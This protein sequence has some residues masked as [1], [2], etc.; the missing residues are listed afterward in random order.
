MYARDYY[1]KNKARIAEHRKRYRAANKEKIRGSKRRDRG[2]PGALRPEP[3]YCELCGGADSRAL[4]LDH[5]HATGV[6]RGWI[7]NLCNMGLARFRDDPELMRRA[8]A[9]VEASRV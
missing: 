5:C 9:Y 8:A 4:C 6:F 7:C 2:L 1:H 3:K